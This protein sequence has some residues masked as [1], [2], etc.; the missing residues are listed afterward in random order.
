[1]HLPGAWKTDFPEGTVPWC[2]CCL[3]CRDSIRTPAFKQPLSLCTTSVLMYRSNPES[4]VR[5]ARSNYH[6]YYKK[7]KQNL[8]IENKNKNQAPNNLFLLLILENTWVAC[9]ETVGGLA[10]I[11]C[12]TPKTNKKPLCYKQQPCWCIQGG[13]ESNCWGG[14]CST[15]KF[16]FFWNAVRVARGSCIVLTVFFSYWISVSLNH[17]AN[18]E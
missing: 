18:T 12:G 4:L 10:A 15:F 11:P 3:Q 5:L 8:Q 7:K 14:K 16:I 17:F 1:M 9:V 2:Q 13:R 6:W